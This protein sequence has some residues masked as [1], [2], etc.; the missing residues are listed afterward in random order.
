MKIRRLN[1]FDRVWCHHTSGNAY[2]FVRRWVLWFG[3]APEWV[4]HYEDY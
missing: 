1:P 4:Q 2:G 3:L